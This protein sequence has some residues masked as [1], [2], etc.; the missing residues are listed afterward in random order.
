MR[1]NYEHLPADH[2]KISIHQKQLQFLAPEVFKSAN[3]FTVHVVI[4]REPSDS[5]Q[6]KV[7]KCGKVTRY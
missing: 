5:L 7:R 3:E 4:F 6:F 1:E 2:D